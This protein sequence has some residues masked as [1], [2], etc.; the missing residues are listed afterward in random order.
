[1]NNISSV[2]HPIREWFGSDE[3]SDIIELIHNYLDLNEDD[4]LIIP[5]ALADLET[6]EITLDKFWIEI[7]DKLAPLVGEEKTRLA[8]QD[9]NEK[10]LNPIKNDLIAFG[11]MSPETSYRPDAQTQRPPAEEKTSFTHQ[12]RASEPEPFIMHNILPETVA[13]VKSQQIQGLPAPEKQAQGPITAEQS[14]PV[15]VQPEQ[16]NQQTPQKAD[17]RAQLFSPRFSGSGDERHFE[18]PHETRVV[19][20]SQFRTPV[21]KPEEEKE[22]PPI[23]PQNVLNLKK[24][25]SDN[26]RVTGGENTINLKDL[27]I[28]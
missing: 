24:S 25:S 16:P 17:E 22:L 3:F 21:S 23:H 8:V 18:T 26:E 19:N 27:P 2:P 15:E 11:I 9:I 6:K 28:G 4:Q 10:L 7:K 12:E 1:M 14:I 13:P 5:Q 20:Y